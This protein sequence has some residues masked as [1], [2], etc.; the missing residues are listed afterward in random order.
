M[1]QN[2]VSNA[3]LWVTRVGLWILVFWTPIAIAGSLFF[4]YITGK[5]FFFRILTEIIFGFWLALAVVDP[6]YRPRK[7]PLL[8]AM[9]AFISVLT[10][11][12]ILGAD[13]YQSFWSNFER[14][15]GLV[16]YLHMFAFFLIA[17]SVLR[18]RSDWSI[19]FHISVGASLAMS[20]YGLFEQ[21]GMIQV[22]GAS[23]GR[24]FARL[25]NPIY[26]AAYLL[27]HFFILGILWSWVKNTWA[28]AAYV[29][30]FLFELYIFFSTGTRGAVVG[31][32]AGVLAMLLVLVLFS[33]DKRIRLAG[34][35]LVLVGITA[36][37][38]L[39]QFKESGFIRS[40]PFLTRIAETSIVSS[41][42]QS[43]LMIWSMGWQAF[44]ER[45]ILGWGPGNFIIPYAKYYNPNMYGNEPWFD[46][47]HNMHLEWLVAAGVPGFL[48]YV[49]LFAMSG[50]VLWKLQR[51]QALSVFEVA[52][53]VGFIVT[54]L[55]QNT[56]VFDSV[57]TYLFVFLMLA[58]L[59][60]LYSWVSVPVSAG[61]SPRMSGANQNMFLA[62]LCVIL[63]IGMAFWINAKQI[64]SARGIIQMLNAAGTGQGVMPVIQKFDEALKLG[65]FGVSEARERYVDMVIQVSFNKDKIP[66]QDFVLL[67]SKGITEMEKEAAEHPD[68]V[69]ASLPLGKL[70]QL[71]F[72]A[73]QSQ[74]DKQKSIE[75]YENALKIAPHY[76][77]LHLGLAET[78][79]VSGDAAKAAE[80]V[81]AVYRT[82]TRPNTF[83]YSTLTVS[84]LS[85]N[86]DLAIDQLT[87]F[88]SLGNSD[89]YPQDIYL[90]PE[91]LEEVV[92]RSFVSKDA[93]GRE[94]FL[95]KILEITESTQSPLAVVYA[96]LAE[97]ELELGKNNEARKYAE[98][99][100][101]VSP[102][103][104]KAELRQFIKNL[105]S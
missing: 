70:Y 69:K 90:E 15:E 2:S 66:A 21:L 10:L 91:K 35:G 102:E 14:M 57:I 99:A 13:P 92:Q 43:R 63:G 98:R 34:G 4:P 97:T 6:T 36:A 8:W 88:H 33:K 94:R 18:S 27:F 42:A 101:E 56:F 48:A 87:Y 19:I 37:V 20:L 59:H 58:F 53:I 7:S 9:V 52:V 44:K 60:G 1:Q 45:P 16:T 65:T 89:I 32:A 50:M 55:V 103:E 72:A 64:Q 47:V 26:L 25:G 29:L 30:I 46:R 80:T 41:T 79:L 96:A 67:V 5:N 22:P 3:L 71:R 51:R 31:L 81:N 82:M 49:G 39:V 74:S 76:P 95:K 38:L 105:P 93:V 11:A 12:T 84:V 40:N 104:Y 73:T 86:F 62:C 68:S 28:R 24:V 100:L 83:I 61:K 75:V 54:Y 23:P 77:A 78:H 17:S 85:N